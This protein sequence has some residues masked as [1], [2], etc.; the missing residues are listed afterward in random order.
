MRV[1]IARVTS[2]V[3]I[4]VI[5]VEVANSFGDMMVLITYRELRKV[6][7][8]APGSETRARVSGSC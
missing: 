8:L 2:R 5:V 7:P 1:G 4:E 6:T 3:L